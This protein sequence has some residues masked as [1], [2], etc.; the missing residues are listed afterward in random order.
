MKFLSAGHVN[1]L[2]Q[3]HREGDLMKEKVTKHNALF[4]EKITGHVDL[5]REHIS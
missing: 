3:K 5:L 4:A 1:V 2:W